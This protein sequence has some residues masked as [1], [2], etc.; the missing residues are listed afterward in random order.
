VLSVYPGRTATPMQARIHE[1]EGR[2][3]LPEFLVQPEDVAE[4]IATAISL[5]RTSELT[6]LH[7]R[8]ARKAEAR[9]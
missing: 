3:Y 4:A 7:L 6:E 1:R 9:V 8:P 2:E 5:S